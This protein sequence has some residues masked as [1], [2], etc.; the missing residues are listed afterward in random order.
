MPWLIAML[1]SNFGSATNV[2]W[3]A[4][5]MQWN[6]S[7]SPC[8][9]RIFVRTM[10]SQ[11]SSSFF[12][13]DSFLPFVDKLTFSLHIFWLHF[14]SLSDMDSR[15]H[16]PMVIWVF[17]TPTYVGLNFIFSHRR[18]F[19][20][21]ALPSSSAGALFQLHIFEK[22][23]KGF[24]TGTQGVNTAACLLSVHEWNKKCMVT[25]GRL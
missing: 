7:K 19:F 8:N 17:S 16:I 11:T 12:I 25:T 4:L 15:A 21:A 3:F 13:T 5:S 24:I 22:M 20:F 1:F 14:Q 23:S 9:V 2:L 10:S 6:I 18:L